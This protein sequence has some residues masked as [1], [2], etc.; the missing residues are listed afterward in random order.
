MV[1][2]RIHLQ[3]AASST[4]GAFENL[5][6]AEKRIKEILKEGFYKTNE[7]SPKKTYYPKHRIEEF[8]VS[9]I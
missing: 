1:T 8:E 9:E 5:N 3:K 6:E 4:V 7:K 2:L